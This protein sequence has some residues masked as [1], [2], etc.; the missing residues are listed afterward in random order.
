[1]R[2]LDLQYT[3]RLEEDFWWFRGMRRITA[4]WIGDLR[5]QTVLDAGCG[6][7][8]HLFWLRGQ[9]GA[10]RVTGIDISMTALRLARGRQAAAGLAQA[11]IADLPFADGSFELVTSFDVISQVPLDLGSPALSVVQRVLRAGGHLSG[12]APAGAGLRSSHDEELQTHTRFSRPQLCA[13]L[14]G[15]GFDVLRSSY[16]NFLLFPVAA[17]RRL[18]KRA[19]LFA[20][21]DVRPLPGALAFLD[22]LLLQALSLEARLLARHAFGFPFGLSLIALARKR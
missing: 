19:G 6:T 13:L 17:T 1:M 3:H 14:S 11:S 5:P 8:F 10:R 22:P 15:A 16:A 18:L 2:D 21:A 7:G 12:R 9:L 4:S 20:G